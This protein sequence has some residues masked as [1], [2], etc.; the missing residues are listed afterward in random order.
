[1]NI[2]IYST[3]RRYAWNKGIHYEISHLNFATTYHPTAESDNEL[4]RQGARNFAILQRGLPLNEW[5]NRCTILS[6]C[7]PNL[8]IAI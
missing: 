5:P 4:R 6:L 1:M 8:T 3:A 2:N 7:T